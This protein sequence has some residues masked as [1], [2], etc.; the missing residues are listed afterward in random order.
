MA[1]LES[2]HADGGDGVGDPVGEHAVRDNQIPGKIITVTGGRWGYDGGFTIYHCIK[3]RVSAWR[4]G[5]EI[6]R[7]AGQGQ[8]YCGEGENGE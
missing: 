1:I 8:A 5:T 3:Q 4:Y 6:V 7:V 2:T